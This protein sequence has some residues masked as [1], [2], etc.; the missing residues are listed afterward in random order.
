MKNLVLQ[1]NET[2]INKSFESTNNVFDQF[3]LFTSSVFS[4]VLEGI[5]MMS[6]NFLK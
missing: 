5:T 1:I 2:A 3:R 6:E 4:Q